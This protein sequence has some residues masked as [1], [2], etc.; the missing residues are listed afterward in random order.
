[1]IFMYKLS[2][3]EGA[4]TMSTAQATPPATRARIEPAVST[5]ERA[6]AAARRARAAAQLRIA[7]ISRQEPHAPA[8]A[9]AWMLRGGRGGQ[10]RL[11][12]MLSFLW[13]QTDG[14]RAVPLSYPAQA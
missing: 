4:T 3:N 13:F 10:L 14:T 8:P 6:K 12:L 11:K 1:M 5:L 7:S 2:S 9:L